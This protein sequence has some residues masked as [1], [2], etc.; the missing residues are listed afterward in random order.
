MNKKIIAFILVCLFFTGCK[1][2]EVDT[3]PRIIDPTID[4]CPVCRMSVIDEHFAAQAID[5]MG[6]AENF[7][8]IG[9]LSIFM[10]RL[11]DSA[12]ENILATYVKDFKTMEWINA[13]DAYYVQG[14]IDTP[15][16]FGIVAF[17][18]ES[19]AQEFAQK[20]EGKQITWEQVLKEKLTIGLDVEFEYEDFDV[21]SLSQ[22]EVVD[23]EE[24]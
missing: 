2:A 17:K 12:N 4:I 23:K 5:N 19:S 16:S 10:R 21:E 13:Q 1:A 15:M 18:T 22:G 9:C 7:D 20:I 8:D 3:N 14:R 24:K 11:G 6:N